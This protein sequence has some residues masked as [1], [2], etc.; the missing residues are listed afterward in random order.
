MQWQM[1][2]LKRHP[3]ALTPLCRGIFLEHGGDCEYISPAHT[4]AVDLVNTPIVSL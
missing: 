2:L 3:V 4:A 1:C